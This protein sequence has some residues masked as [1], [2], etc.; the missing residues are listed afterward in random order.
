MV[1]DMAEQ[2]YRHCIHLLYIV[3]SVAVTLFSAACSSPQYRRELLAADS[4]SMSSPQK[5][6]TLLDS[7]S[8]EMKS[9]PKHEQMYYELLRIKAADKAYINHQSDS[10]VIN[11][12]DYYENG[13]DARLL[14]EAYYYAGSVYRD[15]NDAPRAIEYYQKAEHTL[16]GSNNYRLLSNINAQKGFLYNN[17][18]LYKEAQQAHFKAYRYD[19]LLKD[20]VN[21]VYSLIS[22]ASTYMDI[23]KIDSSIVYFQ[24][25]ASLARKIN[26]KEII[27]DANAQ[28]ASLY[29]RRK[30]YNTA[31]KLLSQNLYDTANI[32][33]SPNYSM[34][35]RIYMQTK[36]YDSAYIYSMRLLDVGT[37]YAKQTASKSLAKIYMMKRDYANADK[38]MERFNS[39]TDSI[40][41]ITASESV[42]RMNS[43]YNY[44]LREKENLELKAKSASRLNVIL[45]FTLVFIIAL[46]GAGAY[47]IRLRQKRKK[48]IE[49][50]RQM[51]KKM[52][53]QS[54]AYIKENEAKIA[55]LEMLLEST[56][57]ENKAL[58]DKIEQQKAELIFANETAKRKQTSNEESRARLADTD[59]YKTMI[60]HIKANKVLHV[61][62]WK[63]LDIAINTEIE[64][65]KQKIYEYHDISIHEYRICM[66]IRLNV[67]VKDMATLLSLS[68]SGISKA[69][70]RLHAKLFENE[71]TAKDFDDF[72]NSL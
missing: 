51:R 5:A 25:A 52:F 57:N 59:I 50:F 70:K 62:E 20:T 67:Q 66:L 63:A 32:D 48:I 8:S 47:F 69:R 11:L 49:K 29:M 53:E 27:G 17:Q 18:Y 28:M 15:L 24:K 2:L 39:C 54:E 23:D 40:L 13:G 31:L 1:R 72:I 34:A 65:F 56:S 19:C 3:A 44:N 10:T 7:M 35:V 58:A 37:I 71:G 26:N 9:A 55:K 38:Y 64:G 22:L 43:L 33:K 42:A 14:P 36:Q 45:I 68:E 41:K 6:I 21:I 4:L 30:D 46:L 16:E 60:Q 61:E 12:V